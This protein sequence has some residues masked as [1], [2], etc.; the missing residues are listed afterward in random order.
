MKEKYYFQHDYNARRDPKLQDVLCDIGVA[1]I[2]I[3][4]CLVEELYEQG[5]KLPLSYCKHIAYS[6]RA[7]L[8]IVERVISDFGLFA[9]D[10]THFW[11]PAA[12]HR[13]QMRNELSVKRTNAINKRWCS[14][15][16]N[17]NELQVKYNS[18]SSVI[19]DGCNV[20]TS[21]IQ[22]TIIKEK[23][24]KKRKE[25]E[26]EN[27]KEESLHVLT[28]EQTEADAC[29]ADWR[30]S[31][32]SYRSSG[33]RVLNQLLADAD[34]ISTQ[35][36]FYPN[37]DIALSLEKAWANFWGTEEGWEHKRKKRSKTINWRSTFTNSLSLESNRVPAVA[38]PQQRKSNYYDIPL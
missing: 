28:A 25:K 6:L 29:A 34:Y 37:C 17:T 10:D 30:N 31:F 26:E 12:L 3:Y 21:V 15:G 5:G 33:Q 23:K 18:N 38:Q 1:G 14:E 7:D 27:T 9:S 19:Q 13:L 4:W 32:D 20:D 2:G 24:E 22:N 35:S 16:K 8:S 11:S 36:K